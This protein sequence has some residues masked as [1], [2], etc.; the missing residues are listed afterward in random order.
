MKEIEPIAIFRSPLT[1]KFGIPRQSGVAGALQGRIV[2][3]PPF[4]REEALR[5]LE[6]FDYLWL[7]WG[8]SGNETQTWKAGDSLM[9]RPPRLGG[10]QRVGVFASRSPFRPNG[11]GL[12]S[13]RIE[14]IEQGEIVVSGADLMD[15]TPIYDLKPYLPYTDAHPEARG[16]FTEKKTWTELIV[17]FSDVAKAALEP[18]MCNVLSTLLAQDPRPSYQTDSERIY[19]MEYA[20]HNIRFQVKERHCIVL[21]AERIITNTNYDDYQ[22]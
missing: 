10:N 6:S 1:T 13:V 22:R 20:G 18:E 16:G 8:F 17:T 5:G 9:V 12:S 14:K 19:G 15:G 3:C 4:R 7:I 21:T 2:F 11:L